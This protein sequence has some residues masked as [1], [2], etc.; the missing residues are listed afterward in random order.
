MRILAMFLATAFLAACEPSDPTVPAPQPTD[1]RPC[2]IGEPDC[3]PTG[4]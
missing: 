4:D 3:V 1:P 2:P